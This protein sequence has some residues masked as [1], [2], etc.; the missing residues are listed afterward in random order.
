VHV[1]RNRVYWA[2]REGFVVLAALKGRLEIKHSGLKNS[3]LRNP[4]RAKGSLYLSIRLHCLSFFF[5]V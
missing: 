3:L 2:F 4:F 1:A 5:S